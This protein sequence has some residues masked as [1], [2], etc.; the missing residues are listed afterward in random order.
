MKIESIDFRSLDT[1]P[2]T[3]ATG[4]LIVGLFASRPLDQQGG[5]AEIDAASSGLLSELAADREL[6]TGVGKTLLIHKPS[7][8]AATRLLIVGLGKPERFDAAIYARAARG[9]GKALR[10]CRATDAICLLPQVEL[11]GQSLAWKTLQAALALDHGD[12]VYSATRA[13]DPAAAP[14]T[15]AVSFP[16]GEG[17][18][19]A[20][21]HAGPIAIGIRRCRLLGDLPPNICNPEYLAET[22]ERLAGEIDGLEVEVLDEKQ[23]DEL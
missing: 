19:D 2:A 22:A 13:P 7:G 9:A 6:P 16:D 11:A 10:N 12:Y 5:A 15:A 23:M 8:L 4:C 1:S 20:L 3:T 18:G 14:A 21:R 17:V